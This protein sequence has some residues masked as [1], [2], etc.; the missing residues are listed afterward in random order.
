VTD[1]ERALTTNDD[2]ALLEQVIMGGDLARL[3]PQQRLTDY[4]RVCESMGLNP[5][6][7]PFQYIKLNNRLTLYATR[8]AADQLRKLH[9]VSITTM[10]VDTDGDMAVITCTGSDDSGRSD[11]DVGV[12]PLKGLGGDARANAILKAVTKAKR[13]L[14]LSI[15][16]LGWLDETEIETIPDALPVTV[17][18]EGEIGNEASSV[19]QTTRS[20]EEP[21]YEPKPQRV[22]TKPAATRGETPT[23][24][25][26]FAKAAASTEPVTL[27]V[28]EVDR[29]WCQTE[30]H[31]NAFHGDLGKMGLSHDDVIALYNKYSGKPALEHITEIQLG[32]N[33]LLALM[34]DLVAIDAAS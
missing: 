12:V 20:E 5:L 15:C 31:R 23:A 28:G 16:G 33:T 4:Q 7:Q 32:R 11:T 3:S 14:T 8:A 6:T 18:I 27:H 26:A 2:G 34:S 19:R 22:A 17:T 9:G 21:V 10:N 1:Q 24:D 30:Y 25:A 29:H 13:R